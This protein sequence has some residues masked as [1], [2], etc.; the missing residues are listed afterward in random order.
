[1]RRPRLIRDITVPIGHSIVGG[2]L[3]VREFFDIDEQHGPAI[4]LRQLVERPLHVG[5]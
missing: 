1:M 3:L 2:D 4:G 5:G